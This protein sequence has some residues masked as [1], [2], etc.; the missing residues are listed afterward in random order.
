MPALEGAETT[1]GEVDAVIAILSGASTVARRGIRALGYW[2]T[3]TVK[4]L[5][6]MRAGRFVVAA[7]LLIEQGH[8]VVGATLKL[9]AGVSGLGLLPPVADVD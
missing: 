4:V 3:K 2:Q 9:W 8:E 1:E 7:G 5:V 6:A